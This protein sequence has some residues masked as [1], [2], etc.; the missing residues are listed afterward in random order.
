[1]NDQWGKKVGKAAVIFGAS[2]TDAGSSEEATPCFPEGPA[3]VSAQGEQDVGTLSTLRRVMP[4]VYFVNTPAARSLRHLDLLRHLSTAHQGTALSTPLLDFHVTPGQPLTETTFCA[5][6]EGE[7][8]LLSRLCGTMAA[9]NLSIHTA[10]V[11][12]VRDREGVLGL[13]PGRDIV[14]DTFLVSESYFGHDR[15]MTAKTHKKLKTELC[16]VLRGEVSVGQ[17]LSRK[18]RPFAPLHIHELSVEN[19]PQDLVTRIALRAANSP[20]VLY[21]ATSA[22]A[23]MQL[24]VRVAMISTREEAADDVFFVTDP[25]GQRLPDSRLPSLEDEL[26]ARLQSVGEKSLG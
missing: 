12:T 3:T 11:Y 7:P 16:R 23:Q 25:S 21:R 17:M 4:D 2:R 9:L 8:G 20:G 13:D 5:W 14:L 15:A 24:N 22:L 10:F 18:R 19:R 26:R 1:M 6:D